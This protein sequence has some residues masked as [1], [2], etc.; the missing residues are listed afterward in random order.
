MKKYLLFSLLIVGLLALTGWSLARAMIMEESAEMGEFV[1]LQ[2][3][4]A[5]VPSTEVSEPSL[6]EPQRTRLEFY[7]EPI[8]VCYSSEE[9]MED[10]KELMLQLEEAKEAGNS[11]EAEEIT[12]KITA[13]KQEITESRKECSGVS[14]QQPISEIGRLPEAEE[15]PRPMPAELVAINRCQEVI[16]WEEKIAYYEKLKN[17]SD[18][19]LEKETGFSREEIEEILIE[20]SAGLDKV[21]EQCSIQMETTVTGPIISIEKIGI[22]EPVKP[23]VV[24]SGQEIDVYYRAKLENITAI[25]DIDEQM[26]KLKT[27]RDETDGLIGKLIKSRKEI[28]VGEFGNIVTEIKLSRGE[29]KADNVV[30]KTTVKKVLFEVGQK[31]ISIEP[32]EKDVLIKDGGLEVRAAEVSIKGNKLRVGDSE[33]N[34]SASAVAEKLEIS[35]K[36][37]ELKEEAEKAVYKMIV[38]EPRKLFG[39]IPLTIQKTVTV[40]ADNGD[41][42]R[43]QRPWYA[44]FTTKF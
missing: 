2:T 28:E 31:S 8:S 35:P 23:V 43:E 7:A 33:V 37:V 6:D 13:L 36:S 20:L 10:Y 25:A 32:T 24:E 21:N 44:F 22:S 14:S 19:E 34:I 11:L 27:L 39:F 18:D 26:G 16:R 9:L 3:I 4:R 40:D 38:L 30:V 41:L 15:V 12:K 29:I 5:P 17:L 1:P 42:L